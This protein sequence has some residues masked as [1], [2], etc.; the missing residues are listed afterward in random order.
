MKE[1]VEQLKSK[2]WFAHMLRTVERFNNRLGSQFG[3]AITYFSILALVPILLFAYAVLGFVLTVLRPDLIDNVVDMF[4]NSLGGGMDMATRQQLIALVNDTLSNWRAVG[5]AALLAAIYSGAG[6][7]GN[8]KNAIRA[9]WRPDF[10]MQEKQGNFLKKTVINLVTLVGLIVLIAVTFAL[11]SISTS[12][13]DDVVRLIGLDQIGWLSPVLRIVPIIFSIG[14]GWLL[15]MYLFTVLPEGRESWPVVRRGALM[16]AIGLGVLQ[17]ST[18][19]LF[20]LF[21]RNRAATI[22]G[23]VIVLM[24]FFNI[25][26]R[27]ILFIAAWIAT[28]HQEAV[29]TPEVKVRFPLTPAGEQGAAE[30]GGP[31]GGEPKPVMVPQPIAARSVQVG[32]GAGYV[33][34]TATGVGLGAALAWLLSKTVRGR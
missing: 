23:P 17:Y 29:P 12:L 9:Q 31:A 34:G 20:S 30:E 6:W 19:L 7:M 24:I 27:L 28:A 22:F 4:A 16:G 18:G 1:W 14:A 32:L 10:D 15:F 11:A 13:A 21:A 26:A 3:A 8:L 5:I 33:T 2:P 25:F